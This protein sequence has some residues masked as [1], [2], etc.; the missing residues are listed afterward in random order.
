MGRQSPHLDPNRDRLEKICELN[1]ASNNT[2]D[3]SI[4]GNLSDENVLSKPQN[5]CWESQ[6]G[7][8]NLQEP[9]C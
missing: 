7:A 1:N 9:R 5:V 2:I 3:F 4:Q 8:P 6:W